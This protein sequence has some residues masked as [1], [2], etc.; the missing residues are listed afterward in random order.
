[1]EMSADENIQ[2]LF[3]IMVKKGYDTIK[4]EIII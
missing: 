1:M 2:K 3:K 4:R